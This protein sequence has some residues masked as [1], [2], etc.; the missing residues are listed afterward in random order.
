[1]PG[2]VPSVKPFT[3][4]SLEMVWQ[5]TKPRPRWYLRALHDLLAVGT[6]ERVAVLDDAF[7]EPKL[8]ALVETAVKETGAEG[9]EDERFS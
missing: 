5:A 8:R 2:R 1:M 7:V 6:A 9:G 4:S 3:N